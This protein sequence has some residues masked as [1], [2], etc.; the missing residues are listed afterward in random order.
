MHSI[1]SMWQVKDLAFKKNETGKTE[2][3]LYS[4]IIFVTSSGHKKKKNARKKP[5]YLHKERQ[6]NCKEP[7]DVELKEGEMW[8]VIRFNY[9][10]NHELLNANHTFTFRSHKG[11]KGC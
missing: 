10:H 11:V 4:K 7:M 8:V 5:R 2:L 1:I 3:A 6:T 9:K